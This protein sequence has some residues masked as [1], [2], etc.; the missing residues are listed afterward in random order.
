MKIAIIGAGAM[1]GAIARGLVK[2][3]MGARDIRVANPDARKLADYKKLGMQVT[4]SNVEAARGADL[5]I[6]AVKPWVVPG[7]LKELTG[8][9]AE[10]DPEVAIV[11]AGVSSEDILG[12]LG[13]KRES[14]PNVSLV[15][16]NLA[17]E[18]GMSMTFI[19]PIGNTSSLTTGLFQRLGGVMKI[20][21]RQLPGAMALASCGL[22]Y[23][24]RYVRAATEGG[25]ELGFRAREAQ[26]IVA[27]TMV[28]AVAMLA[29]GD[30]HPEQLIDSVT[31][32]GG[33]TIR[34]L[35]AMERAGFTNAVIEG[36]R[37]SV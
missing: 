17:V 5:V 1:G 22:A 9:I 32:P 37:A 21:E 2:A 28:G 16:P 26:N 36:L 13:A 8:V 24:L 27:Q 11:A 4:T 31:T 30:G 3:G 6:V 29:K 19:V 33:Y 23:A 12:W 20:T 34:G 25:V 15:M 10:G 14:A 7:V 35:N 18:G